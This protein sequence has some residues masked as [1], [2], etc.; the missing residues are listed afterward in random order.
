M[1]ADLKRAVEIQRRYY[2]ATSDRYEQ[3]HAHEASDDPLATDF[4]CAMLRMIEARSVLDVGTATGRGMCNL[5]EALPKLFV[6]GAEPVAALVNQ[7][8]HLGHGACGS[9]VRCTGERLPFPD[10]SFDAVCEFGILHHVPHPDAVV[11]EMLRV[12]RKA[13][14]L[15]DSNRFGQGPLAARIIKLL[16]FKMKLWRA[17]NYIRTGG[18]NYQMTDG[19]GLAYSYSVYDS[20]SQIAEWAERLVLVPA[21]GSK[22][23]SWLHPLL[24]S[25]G[26]LVCAFGALHPKPTRETH[27]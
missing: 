24:N 17:F 18:K 4:V 14:F 2:A 3:M 10:D 16:L 25:G 15:C 22:A 19:D 26:V 11:R 23:S 8:V 20:L 12:A 6:C 13:V 27:A 5:K 21:D 7:G 1:S 9:F